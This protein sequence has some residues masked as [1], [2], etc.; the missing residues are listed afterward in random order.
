M[1][2]YYRLNFFGDFPAA[3]NNI[4]GTRLLDFRVPLL[5]FVVFFTFVNV[6]KSV[7]NLCNLHII[8]RTALV[9][10]NISKKP[11]LK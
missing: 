8:V 10:L 7:H 3:F 4:C 5:F 6:E 1:W 11:R 2:R 9:R